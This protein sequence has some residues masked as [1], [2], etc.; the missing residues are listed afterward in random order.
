MLGE[1]IGALTGP[2]VSWLESREQLKAKKLEGKIRI[3]EAK[4]KAEEARWHETAKAD[5]EYDVEAQRQMALSWKDEYIMFIMTLPV[6]GSFIPGIQD[7]VAKG[8]E[9]VALAPTWFQ[10]SLIGIISATFGLR[11]LFKISNPIKGLGGN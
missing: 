5:S 6:I 1:I 2:V 7:H 11:W 10:W 4:I 9:Y 8:W 3:E